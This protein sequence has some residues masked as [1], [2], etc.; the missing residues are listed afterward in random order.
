MNLNWIL[1][2]LTMYGA[3]AAGWIAL[4]YLAISCRVDM[5]RERKN[6]DGET[7]TLRETTEA[8]RQTVSQLSTKLSEMATE[9]RERVVP[10]AADTPGLA[11]N[12]NKRWEALR[13]FRHGADPHTVSGALGMPVAEVALLQTVHG[14]I[15]EQT[16]EGGRPAAKAVAYSYQPAR[17]SQAVSSRREYSPEA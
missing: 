14:I 4:L 13:M 11:I 16:N 2:P 8:L 9:A 7:E 15:A 1:S 10:L 5:A 3:M 12:L 6:R 17:S